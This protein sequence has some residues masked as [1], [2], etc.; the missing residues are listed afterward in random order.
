MKKKVIIPAAVSVLVSFYGNAGWFNSSESPE[1]AIE[2]L[3]GMEVEFCENIEF[4]KMIDAYTNGTAEWEAKKIGDEAFYINISGDVIYRGSMGEL[5]QQYMLSGNATS[6]RT[7]K[8]SGR[9][10]SQFETARMQNEMC[11]STK[12]ASKRTTPPFPLKIIGAEFSGEG[13]YLETNDGSKSIYALGLSE[14]EIKLVEKASGRKEWVCVDD[15]EYPNHI[16]PSS[17]CM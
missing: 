4:G 15:L 2:T 16:Y 6:L 17:Q 8:L 11:D 3:Q 7:T 14:N 1:D 5:F 9:Y 10:L 12:A 13:L